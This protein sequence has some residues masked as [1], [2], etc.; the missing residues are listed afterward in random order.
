MAA[1][2]CVTV[3]LRKSISIVFSLAR[4]IDFIIARI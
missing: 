4:K 3:S 2:G 1:Q